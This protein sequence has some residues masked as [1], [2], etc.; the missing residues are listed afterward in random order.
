MWKS[1]INL[2]FLQQNQ[3]EDEAALASYQQA[4]SLEP[5]GPADYFYRANVAASCHSMG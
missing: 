3:G 1:Y 2:G 5:E 4:A